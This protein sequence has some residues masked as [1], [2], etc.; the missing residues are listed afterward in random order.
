MFVLVSESY[1]DSDPNTNTIHIT[2]KI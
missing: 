2:T 1:R